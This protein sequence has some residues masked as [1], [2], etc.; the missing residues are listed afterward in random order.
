MNLHEMSGISG[1]FSNLWLQTKNRPQTQFKVPR[2]CGKFNLYHFFFHGLSLG[3]TT[4]RSHIPT[5]FKSVCIS[6]R[7]YHNVFRFRPLRFLK[8]LDQIKFSTFICKKGALNLWVRKSLNVPNRFEQLL[9]KN[10][11]IAKHSQAQ[12]PNKIYSQILLV[13]VNDH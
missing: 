12:S 13:E 10:G 9:K 1:G 2:N 4:K 3:K 8:S 6:D 7:D 5:I 11:L